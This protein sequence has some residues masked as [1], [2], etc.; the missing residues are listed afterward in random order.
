MTKLR[1]LA[2]DHRRCWGPLEASAPAWQASHPSVEITWD[3]RSLHAFGE[4]PLEAVLGNYDLVI[5]DHPFVGEI[6][7]GGADGALRRSPQRR[8]EGLLRTRFGRQVLAVLPA[9]RA[10]MGAAD[11]C[12]LPGRELSAGPAVAASAHG[13]GEP[14]GTCWRSDARRAQGRQ[15]DRPAAGADRRHVPDPDLH[16]PAGRRRGFRR[17]RRGRS[18]PSASCASWPSSRIR[19]RRAG[20]RSSATTTW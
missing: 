15:M 20:T 11:R 4:A 3:R 6:A 16:Q 18:A 1:G 5:Y 19:C 7:E 10:A 12:R 13:A 8:R 9:R 17:A 2:W 14:C